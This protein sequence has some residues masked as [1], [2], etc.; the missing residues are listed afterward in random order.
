MVIINCAQFDWGRK[1]A[2][3]MQA[4]ELIELFCLMMLDRA[5][6]YFL[7]RNGIN[8]GWVQT[9]PVSRIYVFPPDMMKISLV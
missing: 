3:N 9:F 4:V 8:I 6:A 7:E 1:K 5:R 2:M